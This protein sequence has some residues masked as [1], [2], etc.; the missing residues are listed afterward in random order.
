MSDG[1]GTVKREQKGVCRRDARVAYY[2]RQDCDDADESCPVGERES[3]EQDAAHEGAEG[4][5]LG[6]GL[7]EE[8]LEGLTVT[9]F[10]ADLG[11]DGV[12]DG[13]EHGPLVGGEVV[14]GGEG[15]ERH[16]D[17]QLGVHSAGLINRSPQL[18]L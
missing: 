2:S 18:L 13:E 1:G 8:V 15:P 7:G 11:D 6:R 14:D 9:L 4:G 10:P 12:A 16:G 17:G 3:F 5:I